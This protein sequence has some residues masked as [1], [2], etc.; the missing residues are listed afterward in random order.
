MKPERTSDKKKKK[1]DKAPQNAP[2]TEGLNTFDRDRAGS[3]ADE[4]GGAGATIETEAELQ[5]ETEEQRESD[6]K[7]RKQPGKASAALLVAA[8]LSLA[9][10]AHAETY[11]TPFAA[12][13]FSGDTDDSKIT[14]GGGLT[15]APQGGGLGFNVDFAKTPDFFGSSG[16]IDN[17]VTTLTGNLVLISSGR[18]RFYAVGGGGLLK[19][20][21]SGA[22]GLFDIDSNDFGI[23]AGA[24]LLAGGDGPIGLQADLRYFRALRDPEPDDEFDVDFGELD[25]WRASLGVSIRF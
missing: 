25:Y 6:E 11:A 5:Q 17:S 15:F 23:D 18:T 20:R 10:A 9:G 21:V 24:G 22:N 13:A 2:L 19:T 4:G 12:L 8:F 3:L 7:P 1:D 16:V 14:W